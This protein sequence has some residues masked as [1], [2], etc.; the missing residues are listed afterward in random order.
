MLST[1]RQWHDVIKLWRSGLV[2]AAQFLRRPD[3][4]DVATPAIPFED[5]HWA[6]V[7]DEGAALARSLLGVPRCMSACGGAV[8]Q[9]CPAWRELITASYTL[10]LYPICRRPLACV[11]TVS[12]LVR[13]ELVTR[14]AVATLRDGPA[15]DAHNLHN[16][17]WPDYAS[18]IAVEPH[19]YRFALLVRCRLRGPALGS[20][21]FRAEPRISAAPFLDVVESRTA[22]DA[23]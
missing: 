8:G 17:L 10:A 4:A 20:A 13:A 1:L 14:W 6:D 18:R 19:T 9:P 5:P 23:V 11:P 22:H 16:G 21:R 2:A 7:L 12:T 15:S 3:A